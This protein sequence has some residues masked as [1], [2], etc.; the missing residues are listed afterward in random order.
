MTLVSTLPQ[1]RPLTRDD[2]E[3]MPA[4]GHRYELLDGIL[5]VSPAPKPRHQEA[6][7]SLLFALRQAAPRDLLVLTA[8]L[9]VALANDTVLQPDVLVARRSDFSEKDLP[10]AP[11]LAIEVLSPH[12]RRFDLLLKRDR[13]QTAGCPSYW[14]VDVDEPSIIAWQLVDGTY[15]EVARAS[16][17]QRIQVSQPFE[18]A[19]TPTELVG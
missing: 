10:T 17:S 7:A 12:T 16:G 18:V 2:L 13:L 4:D 8:P 11:L 15:V 19:F 5:I 3:A 1:S 6:V 14:V 9:D